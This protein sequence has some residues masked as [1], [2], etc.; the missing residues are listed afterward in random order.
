MAVQ[1][2]VSIGHID[3]PSDHNMQKNFIQCVPGK[4]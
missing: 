2:E 1:Y 4:Q 3:R